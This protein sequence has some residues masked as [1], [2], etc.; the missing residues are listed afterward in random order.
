MS[1]L[2]K[3]PA[4][5]LSRWTHSDLSSTL[6]LY[7]FGWSKIPLLFFCRPVVRLNNKDKIIVSIA[8][9]RRTKNHLGS[10]YFGAL[11]VGAD[12]A[13]GLIAMNRI[14]ARGK[15]VSLIFK[16]LSADFLKRAEGDVYFECNQGIE[17]SQLVD[18]AIKSGE[19]V[20]MPVTVIAT[21]PALSEAVVAEFT[22]VLSL[23]RR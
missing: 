20:E 5:L 7:Y 12:C 6:A 14:K 4:I 1:W 2:K 9:K 23:K 22:L 18:A 21:V 8:L 10:M 3:L 15:N 16:S 13:A 17:I 11:C 19:R